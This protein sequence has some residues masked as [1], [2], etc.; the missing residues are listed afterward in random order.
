MAN[1]ERIEQLKQYVDEWDKMLA[2]ASN[3]RDMALKLK[4]LAVDVRDESG[5]DVLQKQA[6]EADA[7]ART[8][9]KCRTRAQSLLGRAESGEDV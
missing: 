1:N 3:R 4:E 9:H 8:F 2:E 5:Q 7:A 6:D